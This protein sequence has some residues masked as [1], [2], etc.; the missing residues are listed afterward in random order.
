MDCSGSGLGQVAGAGE[1]SDLTLGSTQCR[2]F[3]D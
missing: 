3:L 1:C 2:E